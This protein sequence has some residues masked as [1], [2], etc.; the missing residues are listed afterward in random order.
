MERQQCPRPSQSQVRTSSS[1][2]TQGRQTKLKQLKRT[3]L[4]RS[5]T[6]TEYNRKLQFHFILAILILDLL[7]HCL[8]RGRQNYRRAITGNWDDLRFSTCACSYNRQGSQTYTLS[9]ERYILG[10]TIVIPK[11]SSLKFN[12]IAQFNWTHGFTGR[13]PIPS[14]IQLCSTLAHQVGIRR[15]LKYNQGYPNNPKQMGWL[16]T[17]VEIPN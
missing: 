13:I 3:V 14:F 10:F 4:H 9:W 2:P 1:I 8:R 5:S 6:A 11:K 16:L 12:S 15:T 7:L 17:L